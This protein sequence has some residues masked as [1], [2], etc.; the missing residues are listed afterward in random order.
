MVNRFPKKPKLHEGYVVY[1]IVERGHVVY[2]GVS[3]NMELRA[4]SHVRDGR[5][6]AG[7][8]IRIVLRFDDK[9]EAEA[10]E[11]ERI[12]EL[13]P[14]LNV[15]LPANTPYVHS[16]NTIERI[17]WNSAANKNDA[18]A[19]DAVNEYRESRGDPPIKALA[20]L[21]ER[22]GDRCPDPHAAV[23]AYLQANKPQR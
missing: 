17:L 1:D 10:A 5:L 22:F 18:E 8:E 14:F 21:V 19:M 12:I 7:S 2:V 9:E 4:R 3:S 16:Q 23:R 20:E 13:R 11:A 6:H 15:R